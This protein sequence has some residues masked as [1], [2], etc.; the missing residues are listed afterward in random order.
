MITL[1]VD[2]HV[3]VPMRD[4]VTLSAD[5]YRPASG[6]PFPVVITRTPY[7]KATRGPSPLLLRLASAG[8]AVMVQD[9]RG[10]YASEGT[11]V[12]FVHERD[13]GFDTLEWLVEQPWCDGKVGMYGG[14]YVGLTQWQAAMSGHPALRAIVPNVTASNYH[15]GWAYQ[16]GAFELGFNLSWAA[17]VLSIDT[18]LKAH[19][20]NMSAPEIQALFDVIDGQTEAFARVPLRGHEILRSFA[21]Y[22]DAWLDHPHYD[23][24]WSSLD[25]SR[26]YASLDVAALNMGGWYDIFL[27]GTLENFTGM[28]SASGDPS[29]H[30]LVIGPWN[31]GGMQSGNPIGGVDFG[32]RSTGAIIDEA[33]MHQRW[34]DRWLRDEDNG[35]EREPPVRVFVMGAGRW[36]TAESWPLP[37]TDFQSWYLHSGGRANTAGGDGTL[38]REEPGDEPAD[39]FL[40]NPHNPVP[41]VGGP[42]CCNN[43]F[44][45]GGAYDQRNVEQREDVLVYTSAPLERDVEVTGPL[46]VILHAA[47]TAPD[48]DF[49]AKL[50]DVE[51]C[52]FARNVIDGIIRAR[53]RR[54][55]TDPEPIV[56]GEIVEYEIDLIGT[57]NL[58]RADHR[59]RVEISSSNF[60]RFD[61]NA[62]TGEAPADATS[63]VSAMQT[64][65]HDR[66][67]PS[68]IILPVVSD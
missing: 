65:Y 62:N 36:K 66:S 7:D 10:R 41:T 3:P 35:I 55:M 29:R 15:N 8:Y 48:T 59:I 24:F 67:T 58:F 23:D 49:T 54:S 13:D 52:G 14:S 32:I 45:L 56:P 21:P 17:S 25:V 42:L 39:T 43:V 16:G 9:T 61:R 44:T 57:S 6:G 40:Y 33:G 27:S 38:T 19:E 60:P 30:H 46:T 68:R 22:Y 51:P 11:F 53:Y 2:R 50:V 63:M 18:A 12:P 1:T 64:V 20:K 5:V 26:A 47:S 31:H 37:G 28:R 4:G 34:F